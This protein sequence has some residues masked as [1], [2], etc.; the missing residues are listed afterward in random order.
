SQ[1]AAT[2]AANMM[3]Q[4]GNIASTVMTV[5]TV[6]VVSMMMIQL[7]WACEKEEFELNAKR[8]LKSCHYVG[9]Y[10]KTK[11]LGACIEKRESYCCYNSPLSRI[12][13]EQIR[14]QMNL[15]FGTAKA[16]SC[17]GLKIED[18]GKV[19]WDQINLDEWLGIL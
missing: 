11:V 4:V 5:Y 7:I 2:D 16:P 12:M 13:N 18:I 17:D 3:A 6:Y 10:C 8:S 9:S 15:G 19:D 1:Q 14:G